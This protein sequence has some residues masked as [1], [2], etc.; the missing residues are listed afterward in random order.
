METQPDQNELHS[1]LTENTHLKET[2]IALREK[3]EGLLVQNENRVQ[4]RSHLERADVRHLIYDTTLA[5]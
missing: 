5:S 1:V 2:I 3:L 4:V